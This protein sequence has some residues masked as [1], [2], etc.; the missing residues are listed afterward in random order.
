MPNFTGGVVDTGGKFAT[1]VVDTGGAP[2]LANISVNFREIQNGPN[3]IFR[4][5]G[6]D[7]LFVVLFALHASTHACCICRAVVDY[8]FYRSRSKSRSSP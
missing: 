3:V 2:G 7:I 5:L 6:E 4:G 1:C 8:R